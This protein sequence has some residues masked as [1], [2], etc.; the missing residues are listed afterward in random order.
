MDRELKVLTESPEFER[1]HEK[2][3]SRAFNPFDVLEV[4]ELEIRHSNVLAGCFGRTAHTESA[5]DSCAR[6]STTW[7]ID[8]TSRLSRP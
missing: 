8:T 3:R 7:R 6:S 5:A 4:S 2:L 1:Y